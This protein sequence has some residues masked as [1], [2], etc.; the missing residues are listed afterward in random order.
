MKLNEADVRLFYK[1]HPSLLLYTNQ[2]LKLFSAVSTLNEFQNLSVK[3]KMKIRDA[4]YD[5]INLI[6]SF[7]KEN[8]FNF[9]NGAL[10]IVF[11]W[12][13]FVKGTFSLIS[14]LKKYTI[15]LSSDSPAKAYGVVAITDTFE[16]KL[17]HCLPIMLDAVL[18]PFKEQI[19]YDG[20][21][22]TYRVIFGVGIGRDLNISFQEAKSRFGIIT[23][24]PFLKEE[25]E[26][27]TVARL[28]FYLRS[29]GSYEINQEEIENLIDEDQNLLTV[30]HQE[31][32]KLHARTYRKQLRKIGL[33]NVWFAIFEG[34][35]I[36]SGKT[37]ED[38][39]RTLNEILPA[40]KVKF[41]YLFPVKA[42]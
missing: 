40:Q 32:G 1:L 24:L 27:S 7:V 17:G 21:L 2:Q 22:N 33:T 35:I 8:P 19:I 3:E 34:V 16:E 30:Y 12:K 9:S 38:V 25:L 10:K 6:D 36:A 41:A 26:P 29:K 42:K 20:F 4:L 39:G 13:N 28:K 23:S 14:Y 18:L 11:S 37:K 31:L 5:Q 15:F